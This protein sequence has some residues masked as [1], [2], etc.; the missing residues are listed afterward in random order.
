MP[1]IT[2]TILQNPYYFRLDESRCWWLE[3]HIH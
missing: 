2:E 3:G 1:G